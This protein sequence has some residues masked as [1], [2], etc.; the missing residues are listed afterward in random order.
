MSRSC[1]CTPLWTTCTPGTSWTRFFGDDY[2]SWYEIQVPTPEVRY[3]WF[4]LL[5]SILMDSS[6]PDRAI[7]NHLTLTLRR[8]FFRVLQLTCWANSDRNGSTLTNTVI[9]VTPISSTSTTKGSWDHRWTVV[10]T[11]SKITGRGP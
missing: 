9:T 4:F 10:L 3:R 5:E 6:N 1:D 8:S 2:H 11:F 7:I